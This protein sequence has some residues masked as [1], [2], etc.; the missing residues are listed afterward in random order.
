VYWGRRRIKNAEPS[1]WVY[2]GRG[3]SADRKRIFHLHH[4]LLGAE[5]ATF[6]VVRLPI[7]GNYATDGNRCFWNGSEIPAQE[8]LER[9]H[10]YFKKGLAWWFA[11]HP[12]MHKLRTQHRP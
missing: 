4:E 1:S 7:G 10:K 3:Y 6:A 9:V 12:V 5:R 11:K 2:L 8:F